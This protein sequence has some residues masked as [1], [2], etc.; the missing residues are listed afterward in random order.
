MPLSYGHMAVL[1]LRIIP[2]P[3]LRQTAKD[4]PLAEIRKLRSLV[5]DMVQTM[6]ASQGVGLAAPQV[7]RGLRLIVVSTVQGPLALFNPVLSR[8]SLRTELGEEGCLSI[9][10]VY[11]SVRRSVRVAVSGIAPDGK[12]LRFTAKGFFAR[13]LQHEVDHLNGVLFIDRIKKITAGSKRLEAMLGS[14]AVA[15]A[16]GQPSG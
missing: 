11:G 12:P 13:V 9:P 14:T 8:R 1:P 15:S 4:V 5:V 16:P 2:D 3:V 6:D 7:G 10:G